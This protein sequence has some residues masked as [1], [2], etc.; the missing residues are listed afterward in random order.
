M[1]HIRKGISNTYYTDHTN[2]RVGVTFFE[3]KLAY[4]WMGVGLWCLTSLSTIFQLYCG[5]QFYW[6]RKPEYP[7]KTTD[8]SQVTDK[9]YH[10]MLYQVHFTWVGFEFTMLVVIGT[11]CIVSN[12]SNYHT[13]TTTTVA[14]KLKKNFIVTFPFAKVYL[15]L[16]YMITRSHPQS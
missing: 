2:I 1:K 4:N 14:V 11:D 6:W 10:I 12:K 15:E 9:L 8:L 3:I 16:L 5:S 13:I 7:K